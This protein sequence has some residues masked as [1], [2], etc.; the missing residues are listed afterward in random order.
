MKTHTD[1]DCIFCTRYDIF[2]LAQFY[3][4]AQIGTA[5]QASSPKTYTGQPSGWPFFCLFH[6]G[7]PSTASAMTLPGVGTVITLM[8]IQPKQ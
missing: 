6:T 7:H 8:M 4:A 2:A 5:F 1:M 3:A